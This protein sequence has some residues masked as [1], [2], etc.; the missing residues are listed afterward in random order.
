MRARQNVPCRG[1]RVRARARG[2]RRQNRAPAGAGTGSAPEKHPL[3]GSRTGS[4]PRDAPRR[5][6]RKWGTPRRRGE[7]PGL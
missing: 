4:Y 2:V 1:G 6:N 5:G 3:L 7:F